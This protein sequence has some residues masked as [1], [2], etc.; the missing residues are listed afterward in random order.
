MT[1]GTGRTFD[2]SLLYIGLVQSLHRVGGDSVKDPIIVVDCFVFFQLFWQWLQDLTVCIIVPFCIAICSPSQLHGTRHLEPSAIALDCMPAFFHFC[3][4]DER[5]TH[6]DGCQSL[7]IDCG[8]VKIH[9]EHDKL[10]Y[11]FT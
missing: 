1:S 6:R 11:S 7:I 10:P 8:T 3:D 9:V 2:L 5:S 4:I